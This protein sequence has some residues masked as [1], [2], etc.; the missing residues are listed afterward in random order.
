[1]KIGYP[2]KIIKSLNAIAALLLWPMVNFAQKDTL[3]T[4]LKL[5]GYLETYYTAAPHS[6]NN[7]IAPFIFNHAKT[8]TFALNLAMIKA[9]VSKKNYRA[10]F[11]LHGGTYV[12]ANYDQSLGTLRFIHEAQ[13]GIKIS[14][15][16]RLWLDAGI[17]PSHIGAE[18]AVGQDNLTL[19]RSLMAELSPY[20]ETGAKLTYYFG[21][22]KGNV[23]LIASNGWQMINND[24][25]IAPA[26]GTL[27]NYK[28]NES[29]SVSHNTYYG[30]A[31][32]DLIGQLAMRFYSNLYLKYSASKLNLLFSFDNGT[33]ESNFKINMPLFWT[34]YAAIAKY[35]LTKNISLCYRIENFTDKKSAVVIEGNFPALDH[36]ILGNSLNMDYA[37]SENTWLRVEYKWLSATE[38]LFKENNKKSINCLTFSL[39]AKL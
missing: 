15:N 25:R 16:E 34:A 14:K 26:L 27:F 39:S 29:W 1:M 11:A 35:S 21:N 22:G 36:T 33:Q 37:L 10:S 20:Y 38:S 9:A 4:E 5:S 6:F 12:N 24:D 23:G 2:T 17:M 30:K 19:T 31:P 3:D 28:F 7:N 8:K 13:V 18:S 32:S